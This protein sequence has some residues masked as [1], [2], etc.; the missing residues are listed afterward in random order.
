MINLIA[1]LKA[2]YK[3]ERLFLP[4]DVNVVL[5]KRNSADDGWDTLR[6]LVKNGSTGHWTMY[7]KNDTWSNANNNTKYLV[8]SIVHDTWVKDVLDQT[9][10]VETQG[11]QYKFTRLHDP[12]LGSEPYWE[13]KLE[14][15]KWV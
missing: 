13:L 12:L 5:K 10:V 11:R 14:F 9:E 3:V 8:L 4:D 6:T 7:E 15:L 2:Q 1:P